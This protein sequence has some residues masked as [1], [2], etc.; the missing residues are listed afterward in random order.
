[1]ALELV[2]PERAA[3]LLAGGR[4]NRALD[5]GVVADLVSAMRD[6]S[7]NA[8]EGRPLQLRGGKL[9]NGQHRLTAVVELGEPVELQVVGK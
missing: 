8:R 7:F 6:G 1:M 9:Q 4:R 3:K 2:T 5:P